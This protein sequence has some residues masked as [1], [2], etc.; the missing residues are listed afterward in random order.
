MQRRA[1]DSEE[2]AARRSTRER[3][4]RVTAAVVSSHSAD[5]YRFLC[6]YLMRFFV[7]LATSTRTKR[8]AAAEKRPRRRFAASSLRRHRRVLVAAERI[9]YFFRVLSVITRTYTSFSKVH[10]Y[11]WRVPFAGGL[12][13]SCT[14]FNLEHVLFGTPRRGSQSQLPRAAASLSNVSSLFQRSAH[15]IAGYCNGTELCAR[16]VGVKRLARGGGPSE[17]HRRRPLRA[18]KEAP[19][20]VRPPANGYIGQRV[21]ARINYCVSSTTTALETPRLGRR[22]VTRGT[23][24]P[25]VVRPTRRRGDAIAYRKKSG[26]RRVTSGSPRRGAGSN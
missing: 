18:R 19:L 25:L 15:F 21:D 6:D 5:F 26:A 23:A 22:R 20:V 16:V 4:R 13:T 12:T 1:E 2:R 14:S 9:M 3:R 8:P 7:L 17:E 10:R 11:I 24:R